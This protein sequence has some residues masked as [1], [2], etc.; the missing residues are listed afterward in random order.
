VFPLAIRIRNRTG[1]LVTVELNTRETIHLA[2]DEVSRPIEEYEAKDNRQ[3]HKLIDRH[4]IDSSEDEAPRPVA[5]ANAKRSRA[6]A[7]E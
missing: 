6:S 3:L 4:E 5:P 7:Q 1:H 2:P